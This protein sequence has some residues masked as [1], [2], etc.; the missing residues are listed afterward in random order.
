VRVGVVRQQ[1]HDLAEF[2]DGC[3]EVALRGKFPGSLGTLI[4][5]FGVHRSCFVVM[6]FAK[7][8]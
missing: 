7:G 1:T 4:Y 2:R 5:F 3:F 8:E 6:L